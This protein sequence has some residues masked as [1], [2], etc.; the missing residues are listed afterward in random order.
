[1]MEEKVVKIGIYTTYKL[2]L[3]TI[4]EQFLKKSLLNLNL[5]ET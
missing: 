2:F 4:S 3:D 5:D 1:M